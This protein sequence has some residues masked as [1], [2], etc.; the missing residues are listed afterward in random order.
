MTCQSPA[1]SHMRTPR[2]PEDRDEASGP[3]L[4]TGPT[5]GGVPISLIEELFAR[6]TE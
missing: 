6:G 5:T 1:L 2:L 3:V 4:D